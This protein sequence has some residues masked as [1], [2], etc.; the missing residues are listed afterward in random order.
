[1][2]K[3][4]SLALLVAACASVIA[5]CTSEAEPA[6]ATTHEPAPPASAPEQGSSPEPPAEPEVPDI[7]VANATLPG[8][9]G[10]FEFVENDVVKQM[11]DGGGCGR[12]QARGADDPDR[13]VEASGEWHDSAWSANAYYS[14]DPA[15]V[16]PEADC[17]QVLA[18]MLLI[19]VDAETDP[20]LAQR[21]FDGTLY[22]AEPESAPGVHCAQGG[23]GTNATCA[24]HSAGLMW[25]AF[26]LGGE[27]DLAELGGYL[28]EAMESNG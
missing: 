12:F 10:P 18:T 13:W 5:G 24:A 19:A 6:A 16:V 1:M 25:M 7:R 23:G 17:P 11:Q 2:L 14:T 3:R 27:I 26:Y 20:E 22:S 8:R 15:S 21:R 28:A 4:L 9:L